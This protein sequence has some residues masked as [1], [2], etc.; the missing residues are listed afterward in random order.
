M[1]VGET[2]AGTRPSPIRAT[3]GYAD[4][5]G[6]VAWRDLGGPILLSTSWLKRP[7]ESA[8]YSKAEEIART[9]VHEASHRFAG[10]RDILYKADSLG[11]ELNAMDQA[12]AQRVKQPGETQTEFIKD[13]M[14]NKELLQ[15]A[16]AGAS[17]TVR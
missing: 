10:T 1:N 15:K 12:F 9:L 4:E 3:F 6:H 2:K 16:S 13:R 5:H 7:E 11:V 14:L 8:N 17:T